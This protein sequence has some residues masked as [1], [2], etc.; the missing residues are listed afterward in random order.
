MAKQDLKNLEFKEVEKRVISLGFPKFR[1]GQIW[2]WLRRKEVK[3]IAA[4]KNLSPD[5]R[6]MLEQQ[7][8]ISKINIKDKQESKVD[9]TKKLLFEFED[10]VCVE[11]VI[12]PGEERVSLCIS[13]QAGCALGCRFC[14][15]G[16]LGFIRDLTVGEIINEFE[17]AK[18][19]AGGKID[20]I[21][22]M[23]MGEPFLNKENVLKAIDILSDAKGHNFSQTRITVS[24]AGIV[25][26]IKEIADS[27]YKFN[28]AI[29]LITADDNIRYKLMP[30]TKKY[31]LK[32]VIAAARYYNAKH[33]EP[34]MFEYILFKGLNDSPD[35][36]L[37]VLKLLKGLD[38]KINLIPYNS[39]SE[40]DYHKPAREVTL[41]FQKVLVDA[42]VKAFI[43]REKGSDIAGACGQLAGKK[44]IQ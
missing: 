7:F 40:K 34:V 5:I 22:F 16:E 32:E 43:R 37:K 21:V 18:A 3:E 15:T 26:V 8:Y 17:A 42:G 12:L 10:G 31:S 33:K 9:G 27:E 11:S 36:A 38:Y 1:A 30:I 35:D 25:P 29:S 44:E 14:A 28:L 13:S 4:M 39:V 23:G 20:S 19:E 2:D 6:E 41:K 24:T